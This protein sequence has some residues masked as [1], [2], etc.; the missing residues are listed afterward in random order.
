[1]KRK[2]FSE[3]FALLLRLVAI[4][5]IAAAVWLSSGIERALYLLCLIHFCRPVDAM[6]VNVNDK[7]VVR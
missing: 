1:M 6:T 7:Q 5:S 3:V 4:V 2:L